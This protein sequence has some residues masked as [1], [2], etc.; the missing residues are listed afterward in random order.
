[1]IDQTKKVEPLAARLQV[2]LA[3]DPIKDKAAKFF[4]PALPELWAYSSNR[5]GEVT[6]SLVDIDRAMTAVFNWEL[7]PFAMWDAAGVEH[8][9]AEMRERQMPIPASVEK[10]LLKGGT[11]WYR[12]NGSEYFDVPSGTYRAVKLDNERSSISSYK[13]SNGV[14]AGNGD[15][16][17]IDIGE[18]IG[19]FELHS[20]MNS[21]GEGIVDFLRTE[22]QPESQAVRNFHGFVISTD[23]QNFSVGLDLMQLM[24]AAQNGQ[25]DDI[26]RIIEQFQAMTQA[27]KFCPR[28]VVAAPAGLCLGGGCEIA[29]HSAQRQPHIEFYAGLIET[30]VGLIPGGGGC[31]EMLLRAIADADRVKPDVRGESSALIE[32]LRNAFETIGTKSRSIRGSS[33]TIYRHTCP[34]A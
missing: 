12:A 1:M 3:G 20:K 14:F 24:T 8:V 32:T 33:K 13:R 30:G 11:S 28:P 17:L 31:K 2:L 29:M 25:W 6:E 19:C 23:A 10:L 27:V 26:A 9:V 21:L 15:V 16:S 5:I 7:G 22:L 4:W 34:W 18:G